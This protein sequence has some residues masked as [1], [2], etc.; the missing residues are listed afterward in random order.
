MARRARSLLDRGL[1]K[2]E[3]SR[4]LAE[5][6]GRPKKELYDFLVELD[7]LKE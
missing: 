6:S 4:E 3:A 1:T 7:R 2:K 5:L